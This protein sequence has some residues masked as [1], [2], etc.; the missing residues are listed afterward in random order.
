MLLVKR[1]TKTFYKTNN[2]GGDV[3]MRNVVIPL[4][5]LDRNEVREKGQRFFI[6][7][8]YGTGVSGVEIGGSC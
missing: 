5:A 7:K 1:F 4:N 8:M 2:K 3:N 6:Q